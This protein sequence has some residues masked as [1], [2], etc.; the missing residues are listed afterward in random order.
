VPKL[1]KDMTRQQIK[2][3]AEELPS[4]PVKPPKEGFFVAWIRNRVERRLMSQL[5]KFA[6][7]LRNIL[8]SKTY[9]YITLGLCAINTYMKFDKI[10][11]MVPPALKDKVNTPLERALVKSMNIMNMPIL[12]TIFKLLKSICWWLVRVKTIDFIA[13]SILSWFIE[14]RS[15]T[16]LFID[17]HYETFRVNNL[18]PDYDLVDHMLLVSNESRLSGGVALTRIM[19]FVKTAGKPYSYV[20]C[21][22]YCRVFQETLPL[23]TS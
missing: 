11:N 2:K 23:T 15:A 8:R 7:M 17:T 16:Q 4:E 18:Q 6:I 5:T 22:R 9:G 3:L 19:N 13:D 1:V 20:E 12:P 10:V 21:N 14:G